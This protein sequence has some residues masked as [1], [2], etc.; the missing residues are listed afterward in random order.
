VTTLNLALAQHKIEVV[1]TGDVEIRFAESED[2][3]AIFRMVLRFIEST[4]YGNHIKVD[5]QTLYKTIDQLFS[6][7]DHALLVAD[8]SGQIIGTI[9]IIIFRNLYSGIVESTELFWWVEPEHR[10]TKAGMLLL[11]KAE[12]WS[13]DRGAQYLTMIAPNE[14]IERLYTRRGFTKIETNYRRKL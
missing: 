7:D 11:K 10:R 6:H 8:R 14:R 2:I 5:G 3:D 9:G 13:R 12:M 1:P 4:E